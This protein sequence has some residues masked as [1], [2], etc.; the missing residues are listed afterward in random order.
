V[1]AQGV[2]CKVMPARWAISDAEGYGRYARG[3][4]GGIVVE[5]TNLNDSG[6]GSLR[7][8]VE[9]PTGP[10]TIVFAISGIIHLK[11]RLVLSQPYVTIAGQT[12]PGKGICI[13][14]APFGFTGNDVV[15]RHLRVRLGAGKTADG[16][17]E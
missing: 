1:A 14:G 15:A 16:R 10:R 2:F 7:E 13:A 9:N 8:A 6:P 4:R 17:S 12:A 5:V 11:S 3:G